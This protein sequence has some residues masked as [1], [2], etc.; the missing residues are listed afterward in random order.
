MSL[1]SIRHLCK[2]F[3]NVTPLKDV[4]AEIEKGDVISIIGPSG[5]GKSTFLRCLNRLEKPTSGEMEFEGVNLMDEHADLN[6]VRRK[7]GMVFQSFNL[8][9]HLMVV[10]NVMQAPV[11]LLKVPKQQAYDEAMEL[12]KSVGLADR[13]HS[14]PDEL[15]GGQKQRVAI[16]RTLAMHPD[17]VLFDEPTSALDPTMVG[18]VLG[19]MR[20]LAGQGYTMLVV[21]HE[22]KFAHDVSNRVFYMDQG[23]IYEQGTPQQ[24]FEHP[25]KDRTR[26]FIRRL[27]VFEKTINSKTYDFSSVCTEIAEFGRRQLMSPK[28]IIKMQSLFEEMVQTN[29]IPRLPEKFTLK[30]TVEYSDSEDRCTADICYDGQPYNALTDGDIISLKIALAGTAESSYR[31]EENN[32]IRIVF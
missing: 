30:Y 12:L 26:R 32:R 1:M 31:Y 19:V 11:D 8:F 16:A 9:A 29:I 14:F 27:K 15:S 23:L 13:A 20:N 6:M 2:K 22:M 21:T 5:T 10:E 24:I 18:E 25:E 3:E 28:K 17:M 7:M 4:N